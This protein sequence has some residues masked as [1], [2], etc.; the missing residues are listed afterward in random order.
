MKG[1]IFYVDCTMQFVA[2]RRLLHFM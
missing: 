1:V 2:P